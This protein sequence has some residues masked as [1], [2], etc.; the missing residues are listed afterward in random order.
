MNKKRGKREKLK[1]LI[2]ITFK[3]DERSD[4]NN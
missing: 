2:D 3:E 4:A 1:F